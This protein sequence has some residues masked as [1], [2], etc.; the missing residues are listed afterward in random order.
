MIFKTNLLYD[1][2]IFKLNGLKIIHHLYS[3]Y[4]TQNLY[5]L[6]N[7][8]FIKSEGV[9][10]SRRL[11]G[12]AKERKIERLQYGAVIPGMKAIENEKC[13]KKFRTE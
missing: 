6:Q 7:D 1:F 4:L 13:R 12:V 5:K 2:H 3:Q 8:S 10:E 9:C 11:Q